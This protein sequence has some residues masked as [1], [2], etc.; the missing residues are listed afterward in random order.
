MPISSGSGM[1]ARPSPPPD[2][3]GSPGPP[4]QR[5]PIRES[6]RAA[7]PADQTRSG[8]AAEPSSS[9][10]AE[11]A[12]VSSTARCSSTSCAPSAFQVTALAAASSG[13]SRRGVFRR[14]P[15]AVAGRAAGGAGPGRCGLRRGH[16]ERRPWRWRWGRPADRVSVPLAAA[17]AAA[18]DLPG[19]AWVPLY[20]FRWR[21]STDRSRSGQLVRRNHPSSLFAIICFRR[22]TRSGRHRLFDCDLSRATGAVEETRLADG[23]ALLDVL[24]QEFL[25][26]LASTERRAV[27]QRLDAL[28]ANQPPDEASPSRPKRPA[29]SAALPKLVPSP[30]SDSG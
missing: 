17:R 24:E 26:E 14:G 19:A 2:H 30:Y 10:A 9:T 22:P 16:A 11:V 27:V 8:S 20:R 25:L 1:A 13:A 18:G 7:R 28:A 29:A 3:G 12:T 15:T 23:T 6:R 4:C 5:D 21:R